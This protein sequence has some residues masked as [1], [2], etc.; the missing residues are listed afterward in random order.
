MMAAEDV[1]RAAGVRLPLGM[2]ADL[3]ST[4]ST[5]AD[6]HGQRHLPA[7]LPAAVAGR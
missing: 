4:E 1:V 3:L 6:K 2:M 5:R 7:G